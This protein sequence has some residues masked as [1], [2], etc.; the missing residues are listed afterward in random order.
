MAP[1]RTCTVPDAPALNVIELAPSVAASAPGAATERSNVS[2]A[3]PVLVTFNW[4]VA[5][6]PPELGMNC[7]STPILKTFSEPAACPLLVGFVVD[8]ATKSNDVSPV[9]ALLGAVTVN[10]TSR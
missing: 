7:T 3:L 6:G 10:E 4:Y 5:L 8:V 9:A 2:V 1:T